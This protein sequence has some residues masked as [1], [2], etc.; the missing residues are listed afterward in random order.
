MADDD[1]AVPMSHE[2]TL[3]R[4]TKIQDLRGTLYHINVG[5]AYALPAPIDLSLLPLSS[6]VLPAILAQ[7]SQI[8]LTSNGGG[9][10][11]EILSL[12]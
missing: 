11:G 7:N 5:M 12:C 10:W 2:S 4:L 1:E 8:E 9:G 6:V 3:L